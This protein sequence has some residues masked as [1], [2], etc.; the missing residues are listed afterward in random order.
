M[1]SVSLS[2][3]QVLNINAC[4]A[5]PRYNKIMH[6]ASLCGE[7]SARQRLQSHTAGLDEVVVPQWTLTGR[8]RAD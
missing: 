3:T 1:R 7:L 8:F 2:T 5:A 4:P 6:I